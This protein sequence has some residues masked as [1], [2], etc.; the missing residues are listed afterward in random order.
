[1][2][3]NSLSLS[4]TASAPTALSTH[5]V[6]LSG[7]LVNVTIPLYG[8]ICIDEYK[9]TLGRYQNPL[10]L[11]QTVTNANQTMYSFYFSVDLCRQNLTGVNFTVV[12]ITNGVEGDELIS[13]AMDTLERS[14]KS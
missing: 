10:T 5:P 11:H 7:I 2:Y 3:G 13:E 8:G 14:S 6:G 4:G 1:M 9:V 12:A